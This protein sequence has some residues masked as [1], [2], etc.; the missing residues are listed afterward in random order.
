MDKSIFKEL[1]TKIDHETSLRDELSS[2]VE[3][4]DQETK[5]LRLLLG[6]VEISN[7]E[8]SIDITRS[9]EVIKVKIQELAKLASEHS[10]YKYVNVWDRTIQEVAC[11]ILLA[12]WRGALRGHEDKK[13][14]IL[15]LEEVGQILNVPVYPE[16]VKFHIS[17][18][19]YLH[20]VL[21][22]SS[23]LARF[24]VNAVIHGNKEVPLKSLQTIENVHSSF[25]LLSLKNDS[26][27]RHFD[28]LKYQLKRAE[29]V[30]YDMRIHNLLD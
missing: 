2:R 16:E 6:E 9:T 30:V 5:V 15:T 24:S 13:Y 18:E 1:Q 22:I 7:N 11:L 8:V 29:D 19:E 25:Q 12:T 21:S 28:S 23:E 3:T 20:G 17:I 14:Q 4:I 26:L 27:R 10:Y